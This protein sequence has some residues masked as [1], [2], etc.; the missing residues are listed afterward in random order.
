MSM[1]AAE[2]GNPCVLVVEDDPISSDVLRRYLEQEGYASVSAA[3]GREA[4]ELYREGA[5]P[6]VIT[7]WLMPEMDGT[8][9]CR[10]IRGMA[11]DRYTYLILLTAR[12]S[13]DELVDGL[14]AGADE[15]LIKPIHPGELRLR[16]KGARRVVDLEASL[17][18]NLAEIR[19][20]SIRDPLTGAFNRGYMDQQ[21]QQEIQRASRYSHPLSVII[22]DIDH[23]K[24]V[25][26]SFGHQTGDEA[27]RKCVADI[28]RSIRRGID[29]VARYGGEEF[30]IVLPE[31]EQQGCRAVA[32]RI[33]KQIASTPVSCHGHEFTL[34]ASFGAVTVMPG[35]TSRTA[36][37]D[38]VLHLADSCLYQA[39]E[40]GRNRVIAA[41]FNGEAHVGNP[42]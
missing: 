6:I 22:G 1:A 8:D 10:A 7:D 20:L 12:D 27:I 30:V 36:T 33:R 41:R 39:K 13:H 3:N 16:L 38:A 17:K 34:T 40:Q 4:L 19:E 32:E 29:W 11:S 35:D 26:D 31:T 42:H 18:R 14:E 23:F 21:L 24:R 37:V 28:N 9:L 5:F 15:Y 25:N 2:S